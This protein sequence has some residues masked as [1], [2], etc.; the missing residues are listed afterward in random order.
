MEEK[1]KMPGKLYNRNEVSENYI[2]ETRRVQKEIYEC[3]VSIYEESDSNVFISAFAI[4]TANFL[5]EAFK[6]EYLENGVSLIL[7]AIV[8][9]IE[10]NNNKRLDISIIRE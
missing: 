1:K 4:S 3:L 2:E 9:N 8:K 6:E 7:T 5:N 10:Y